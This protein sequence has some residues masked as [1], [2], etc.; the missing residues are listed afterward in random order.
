MKISI[1]YREKELIENCN[2]LLEKY[3]N[4]TIETSNLPIGDIIIS[5]CADTLLDLEQVIIERKSLQDLASS[6]NDGRYSEQ[7]FR[8]N[9]CNVHNHNIIYLIEGQW[10]NYNKSNRYKSRIT[11]DTLLSAIISINYFKG[12]SLYRTSSV[13]ESAKYILQF[14]DKLEREKG[15]KTAFYKNMET[16]NSS[17]TQEPTIQ[18]PTVISNLN[19]CQSD[20]KVV[21]PDNYCDVSKRV[22]KENITLENIGSILLSQIPNVSSQ[23]AI[24]I[25]ERFKTIKNLIANLETNKKCLNDIMIG[26][27]DKPRRINKT[28]ISNIFK[29]LLAE[30]TD[31]VI[32]IE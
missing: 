26:K 22:K 10:T 29:Y 31:I 9:N 15:K 13:E 3:K 16:H 25:M 12:F 6:I 23:T 19:T 4:I 5:D 11:E 7:S 20:N 8:L 28:A 1:D 24:A 17:T 21:G 32:A 18:D 30:E 27:S 2:A 14:A